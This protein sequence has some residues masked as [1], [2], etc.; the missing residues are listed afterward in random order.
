MLRRLLITIVLALGLAACGDDDAADIS[1]DDARSENSGLV[2]VT[3]AFDQPPSDED[4]EAATSVIGRRLEELGVTGVAIE[5]SGDGL[6]VAYTQ[7]EVVSPATVADVLGA[8]GE[9][10]FRPVLGSVPTDGSPRCEG[11]LTPELDETGQAIL[12]FDLGP[13][14]LTGHG[15]ASASA[16]L[17]DLEQWRVALDLR[18]GSDGLDRFNEIAAACFDRTSTCPTGQVAIVLDDV[19]M[20][21]PTVQQPSFDERGVSIGGQFTEADAHELALVLRSGALPEG[22]TP[23]GIEAPR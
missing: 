4:V 13:P 18:S 12:C 14:G 6:S 1:T 16:Q 11:P 19:V 22:L 15:V 10:T 5:R 8:Q 2:T 17:S 7:T 3:L 20:S 23:Q 9:L 21:A